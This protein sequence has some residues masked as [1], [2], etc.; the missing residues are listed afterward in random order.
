MT[1]GEVNDP[2]AER[3]EVKNTYL[4][5]THADEAGGRFMRLVPTTGTGAGPVP[6]YPA[7]S[8]H[9]ADPTGLEPP[10]GIDVNETVPAMR[11]GGLPIS[12]PKDRW[13]SKASPTEVARQREIASQVLDF[14]TKSLAEPRTVLAAWKALYRAHSFLRTTTASVHP[15]LQPALERTE[16]VVA[17]IGL[18]AAQCSANA[19][20]GLVVNPLAF[21]EDGI[22]IFPVRLLRVGERWRKIPHIDRWQHRASAD[23]RQVE[24]WWRQWPDALPGI[25]LAR[26]K[27]VVVDCDRHG[28]PDGVAAFAELGPMP[29]HPIVTTLSNG[30]HHFFRQPDPPIASNSG[31]NRL[32]IDVLGTSRFVVGLRPSAAVGR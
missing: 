20:G 22:A 11:E 25:A 15:A 7:A 32:G 13:S 17:A 14:L 5:H 26:C 1:D 30:E 9:H 16:A 27:L 12:S 18:W 24:E 31:F 19:K 21:A 23:P 10:L 2:Q 3:R 4:S 6:E 29:P 8:P 28:G